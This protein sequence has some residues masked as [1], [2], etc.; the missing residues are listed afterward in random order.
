MLSRRALT[1]ILEILNNK[2]TS[3][4]LS[5]LSNNDLNNTNLK[6]LCKHL[7][8]LKDS[9]NLKNLKN[10][11]IVNIFINNI[12]VECNKNTDNKDKN[13][14]NDTQQKLTDFMNGFIQHFKN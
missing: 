10:D 14:K 4:I 3:A 6:I 13:D 8:N 11:F 1:E 9:N 12:I 7:N 5:Y 2:D